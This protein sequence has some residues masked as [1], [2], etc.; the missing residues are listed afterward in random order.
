MAVVLDVPSWS[1]GSEPGGLGTAQHTAWL[2][3][4]GWRA[5]AC[6]PQDPLP[7]VWQDLGVAARSGTNR[8]QAPAA[9]LT[10]S[11]S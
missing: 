8:S 7:T 10:G 9:P 11:A 4:H 2:G 5:V 3:A 1:R 6:G